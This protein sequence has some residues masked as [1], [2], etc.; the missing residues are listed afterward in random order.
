MKSHGTVK[1]SAS[2]E[3]SH[4]DVENMISCRL[5]DN[6][7]TKQSE[8]LRYVQFTKNRVDNLGIKQSSCTAMLE[9]EPELALQLEIRK[10]ISV[11]DGLQKLIETDLAKPVDRHMITTIQEM[12]VIVMKLVKLLRISKRQDK[13]LLKT[14]SKQA[15]KMKSACNK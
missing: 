9:V 13:L 8:G 2:F 11:E 1:V 5:K 3:R 12:T 10:D 4:Q 7:S 14:F 6:Q 15:M